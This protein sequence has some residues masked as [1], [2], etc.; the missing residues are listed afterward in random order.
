MK[1]YNNEEKD[2]I[3]L[4]ITLSEKKILFLNLRFKSLHR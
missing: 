3:N 4:E 1:C 2:G